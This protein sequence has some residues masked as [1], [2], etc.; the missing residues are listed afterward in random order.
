MAAS[1]AS[2]K[3]TDI[4][5]RRV[6]YDVLLEVFLSVDAAQWRRRA[7]LLEAARPR[8]GDFTGNATP[9]QLHEQWERLT[10]AAEA[11]RRRANFVDAARARFHETLADVAGGAA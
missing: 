11:C 5:M 4:Y 1:R 2:E 3:R 8:P 9:R 7:E 6:S 10:E